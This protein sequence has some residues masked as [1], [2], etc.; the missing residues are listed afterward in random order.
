MLREAVFLFLRK[1]QLSVR[2]DFK[3]TA[4][5]FDQFRLHPQFLLDRFCQTGSLGIVVSII[6]V[7]DR[8]ALN[9]N[10]SFLAAFQPILAFPPGPFNKRS[11]RDAKIK[12]SSLST[13][14]TDVPAHF[15]VSNT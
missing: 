7:F 12:L 13:L 6:A 8:N 5:G 14:C 15:A 4:V 3:N 1:Y 2:H 9:H 10:L 11:P